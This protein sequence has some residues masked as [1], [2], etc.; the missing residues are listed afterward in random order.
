MERDI[1]I[2]RHLERRRREE[3]R[4]KI[5]QRNRVLSM[6]AIVASFVVLVV[7][8]VSR[9]LW[10]PVA[11]SVVIEAGE[12]LTLERFITHEDAQFVT[13]V[14]E[15]DT[16]KV[17]IHS[18]TVRVGKKEFT[19]LLTI[20]DTTGPKADPIMA[21][22]VPGVLPEPEECVANVEDYSEVTI[23]YKGEP[24]VSEAGEVEVT[25]LLTDEAGN[26]SEVKSM[27]DVAREEAPDEE[28]GTELDT[29]EETG[30]ENE[31]ESSSEE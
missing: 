24:D 31:T 10:N 11:E 1:E 23:S 15:I 4:R 29:E 6:I 17:G 18:V 21:S 28:P 22:T 13:D 30:T 5:R 14:A 3:H 12:E 7:F 27:I 25:V 20:R 8:V 9:I 16:E 19:S 2:A 26:K